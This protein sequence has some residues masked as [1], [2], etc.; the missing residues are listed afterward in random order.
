MNTKKTLS[1]YIKKKFKIEKSLLVDFIDGKIDDYGEPER[2]GKAPDQ[3]REF[4]RRK[5][6][7]TL[8]LLTSLKVKDISKVVGASESL[9]RKW[10][11]E[12]RFKEMIVENQ[13]EFSGHHWQRMKK[14]LMSDNKRVV[15]DDY[16][17][18]SSDLLT[19][20]YKYSEE[21]SKGLKLKTPFALTQFWLKALAE[22]DP[23]RMEYKEK[24]LWACKDDMYESIKNTISNPSA[25]EEECKQ[26]ISSMQIIANIDKSTREGAHIEIS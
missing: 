5:Y 7:T 8:C 12:S 9:L 13:K 19:A 17:I 21:E 25:S 15:F 16:S 11:T 23:E 2:H 4:G 3:P 6:S 1:D 14:W 26:A 10:K 18:Y 24:I 20:V 22:I